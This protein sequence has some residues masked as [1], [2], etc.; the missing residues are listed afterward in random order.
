MT[1]IITTQLAAATACI[2][3]LERIG[4]HVISCRLG[5]YLAEPA[6]HIS[7]PGHALDEHQAQYVDMSNPR[8]F[9]RGVLIDGCRVFW[10]GI[11]ANPAQEETP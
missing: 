2:A 6:I 5:E 1:S 11:Y 3:M 8:S 7:D 4:L 10:I 9:E